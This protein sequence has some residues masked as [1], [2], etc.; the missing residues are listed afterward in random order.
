MNNRIDI[1]IYKFYK[2]DATDVTL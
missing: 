1:I 2:T